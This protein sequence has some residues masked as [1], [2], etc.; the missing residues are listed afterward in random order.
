MR[1]NAILVFMSIFY[2]APN[3]SVTAEEGEASS[4]ARAALNRISNGGDLSALGDYAD[5]E[6]PTAPDYVAS[7]AT[8][9][10]EFRTF[11]RKDL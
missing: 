8:S 9:I 11:F 5:C 10:E 7:G 1:Y 6:S 3:C 2:L 4:L